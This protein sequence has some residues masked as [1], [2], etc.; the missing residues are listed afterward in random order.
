MAKISETDCALSHEK[1][2]G[3]ISETDCAVSHEKKYGKD[4]LISQLF[5][6]LSPVNHKGLYQG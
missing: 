2:Y 3:K 6:V 4:Q 5:G 1:K